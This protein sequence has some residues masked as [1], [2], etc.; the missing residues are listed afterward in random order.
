MTLWLE[1]FAPFALSLCL[2]GSPALAETEGSTGLDAVIAE[3]LKL[4]Q[5]REPKCYATASRLEDV[6]F[7]TP[8]DH[9]ARFAKNRLQTAWVDWIWSEASAKA[10]AEGAEMVAAGHVEAALVDRLQ[11]RTDALGH[12]SVTL[13]TRQVALHANDKRQYASIAYSL[14][15]V[16]AVQ[17]QLMLSPDSERLLLDQ[18]AVAT[19]A[20]ALDY[21]ALAALKLADEQARLSNRQE[22]EAENLSQAWLALS[23]QP[24]PGAEEAVAANVEPP[25]AADLSL[26]RRMIEQK[27]ASYEAYNN[28]SQQLFMRNLQVYFARSRWPADEAA[29][30][31]FRAAFTEAMIRFTRDLYLGAEAK[32]RQRQAAAISEADV[33][34][35]SKA[36]IPHRINEYEDALFFPNLPREQQVAIESYDMDAFRDPGWHWRYLEATINESGFSPQ[37]QLDPFAAELLTE[38]VAQFGVLI[39]RVAGDL[40]RASG[41]EE[42]SVQW[43]QQAF[44]SI[45]QRVDAHAAAAPV[46]ISS[47]AIVSATHSGATA[48]HFTEVAEPM[49]IRY[50]H[51]N[52]DWLNRQLRSFLQKDA[53]TG[54]ITIPPAFG[55]SGVAAEDIDNDGRVD[56]LLL[57]GRG[58]RLYRNTGE[59]FEDITEVAGLAWTRSEDKH[60]G[61]ARQPLI[62]DLDNDG[63]RDI[64]ITYVDDDHR[65]YRNIEGKRFEDV[66]AS[67]GLGGKGL[68]GGPA[69]VFDYDGDGRLDLYIQYFGDYPK[70][71][72]PTLARRNNNGLPDR[73]FRNLGG[74]RFEDVTEQAGL[75]DTGWGQSTTHTDF[76]GDGLQDL[77]SGNDFGTNRYY[78]NLGNGRFQEVS[79]ELGTDK[80][81]FTMS[82]G[83]TDLNRDLRPDIYVSNIV[84]MNKDETYVMPNR[85]MPAK[86]NPEKLK[87]M[88]VVE[89]ND[90]FISGQVA[91]N[92]R[93][94][95]STAVGRG[96]SSTGWAWDADFFD[97]DNDGDDD[98]YVLNGMNEYN[99][100]SREN[101]YYTDPI[102]N[103]RQ[104]VEFPQAGMAA[105]VFFEN[106]DGRF[107]NV[108]AGSGLDVISNSRSAA[109]FDFDGDGDLDVVV[110]DYQGP[111]R[112]FRNESQGNGNH[113]I[114][115]QLVGD[116]AQ[117]VNRDAIGA[118]L[119]ARAG[120]HQVFRE[121]RGSEGYMS[122]HP[123]SQHFGIGRETKVELEVRWPNGRLQTIKGLEAGR[124]HRIVYPVEVGTGE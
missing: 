68:V 30:T 78:R 96:H 92:Q 113:W 54:V 88:R 102:E 121:V 31:A 16:L 99:V 25:A 15:A 60:P 27:L 114:A 82:L 106:H 39:L 44:D 14:R 42:I 33:E 32:A 67:A 84:T 51:R 9:Q 24:M 80:P 26:L 18:G 57:G 117:G 34:A 98:L 65:V 123:R 48:S 101:P 58:N 47:A 72:L 12:H 95:L 7:G 5:Q 85:D 23:G 107:G 75:G 10:R 63:W 53:S 74:F 103:R 22:L 17:Q 73:L 50:Q 20:D 40:G 21:L 13:G 49:G 110:N 36:F 79:A 89:A 1:R 43:L 29:S 41:G 124:L 59:G 66:T 64:V 56:V 97:A 119:V 81:S 69:T 77:I 76:D 46:V 109:Y 70:G 4:E 122:V 120:A 115:V 37:L 8:L 87:A 62:A 111:A 105:N 108:A 6:M 2:A 71:V 61:E 116:P 91:G 52:A 28:V 118:R 38:N 19:L 93:Y 55:G 83:I 45:Q 3:I 35:F 90:L 11:H 100:Y 104:Q 94:Q 86:F 112:L